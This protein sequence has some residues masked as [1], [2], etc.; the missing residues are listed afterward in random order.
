MTV[1][2][3]RARRISRELFLTAVGAHLGALEPWVMDRLTG[4]LEEEELAP[5][6]RVYA[7]GDPPDHFY[8]ARQGRIELTRAGKPAETLEGPG[9]FGMLDALAERPR[10]H[11]AYARTPLQLVRMRID[12]W[13]EL[14]EDSFDLARMSLLGLTRAVGALEERVWASGRPLPRPAPPILEARGGELDVVERLAV[15]MHTPPL[16]GAGVQPLSD[17]AMACDEV[18]FAPGEHLFER[19]VPASRVFVLV[20]GSV[21][22]SRESP[23]VVWRGGCGQIVCGAASFG[24]HGADWEA[25]AVAR[26]RALVFGIDDWFDVMEE[27]FEMVRATLA[28]LAIEHERLVEAL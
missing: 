21:E 22:A 5:G 2:D 19:G 16:R 4:M 28:G 24:E 11:S 1:S 20:D 7:A 13:L 15:L 3:L 6:E 10:S 8:V 14:L 26:T 23:H 12:A 17:L 25:R 18:T 9:A 27:N